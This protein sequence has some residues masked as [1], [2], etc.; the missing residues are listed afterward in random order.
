MKTPSHIRSIIYKRTRREQAREDLLFFVRLI[1]IALLLVGIAAAFSGCSQP[2]T[3]KKT[4]AFSN[5]F[6]KNR[7]HRAVRMTC[8]WEP[9]MLSEKQGT[10]RGFQG[11]IIFFRDEKMQEP[12]I[13]D[14]NLTVFVYDANDH[15]LV[16][17]GGVEGIKPIAEYK[18]EKET[19]DRG[20]SK[21]KKSKMYSYGVWLPIDKLPGDE[22]DLVLWA[23]FEGAGEDGELLSGDQLTVYLPGN[24]VDKKKEQLAGNQQKKRTRDNQFGIQQAVYEDIYDFSGAQMSSYAEAVRTVQ[25]RELQRTERQRDDIIPMSPAMARQLFHSGE[26]SAQTTPSGRQKAKTVPVGFGGGDS[27]RNEKINEVRRQNAN[28]PAAIGFGG[29]VSSQ[30]A[31]AMENQT[32]PQML[33]RFRPNVSSIGGEINSRMQNGQYANM[34]QYERSVGYNAANSGHVQQASYVTDSGQNPHNVRSFES[35]ENRQLITQMMI[36]QEVRRRQEQTINDQGFSTHNANAFVTGQ[37]RITVPDRYESWGVAN[38]SQGQAPSTGQPSNHSAQNRY[39]AQNAGTPQSAYVESDWGPGLEYVQSN[40]E[41]Q[42]IYPSGSAT[43]I[44]R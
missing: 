42:V 38:P 15:T 39:P 29:D 20:L 7:P 27:S 25:D 3:K 8:I 43:R 23:R 40:H 10:T 22:M 31:G 36:E 30:N 28:D 2:M 41:T 17:L 14:G 35:P 5:P 24:P 4:F 44:Y 18:F 19:L 32:P 37:N 26:N 13:V 6:T 9:R 16:D 1:A 11:E 33:S 12:T 21:N 34:T